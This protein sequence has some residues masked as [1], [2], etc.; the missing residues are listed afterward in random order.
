[1]KKFRKICIKPLLIIAGLLIIPG[2]YVGVP[3]VLMLNDFHRVVNADF[4]LPGRIVDEK[5]AE[6]GLLFLHDGRLV[7]VNDNVKILAR[8]HSHHTLC[9]H[10]GYSFIRINNKIYERSGPCISCGVL[11]LPDKPLADITEQDFFSESI[12]PKA[13]IQD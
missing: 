1:M 8:S 3:H 7:I 10:G 5:V 9:L 11:K 4:S 2:L 6:K 12:E 13:V